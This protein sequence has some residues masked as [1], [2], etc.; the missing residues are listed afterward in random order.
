MNLFESL[1]AEEKLEEKARIVC[2][3]YESRVLD[4]ELEPR[5]MHPA[6]ECVQRLYDGNATEDE[7][8][9]ALEIISSHSLKDG[10]SVSAFPGMP[11]SPMR[12]IHDGWKS[13]TP[14]WIFMGRSFPDAAKD[15]GNGWV[16]VQRSLP[17]EFYRLID[18]SAAPP[19]L[20][21]AYHLDQQMGMSA[22]TANCIGP[23]MSLPELIEA[24]DLFGK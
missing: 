20:W 1:Q 17:P 21:I 16:A 18:A 11:G 10:Y 6:Y 3:H 2:E 9:M 5:W 4:N 19:T 12:I 8:Q 22:L 15:I 7:K 23:A 14:T 13:G 24:V